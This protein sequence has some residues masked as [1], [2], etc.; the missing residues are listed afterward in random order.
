M[1]YRCQVHLQI[2]FHPQ[3][4]ILLPHDPICGNIS[5]LQIKVVNYLGQDEPHLG[6]CKT[7]PVSET[8]F[9]SSSKYVLFSNAVAR[10]SAERLHGVKPVIFISR[11]TQKSL[12]SEVPW[13]CP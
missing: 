5:W 10:S 7:I 13:V 9:N 4:I 2:R 11:I 12:R 3:D 6:I 1:S 8:A